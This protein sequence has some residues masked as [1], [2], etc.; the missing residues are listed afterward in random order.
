MR[1]MSDALQLGEGNQEMCVAFIIYQHTQNT[2]ANSCRSAPK[3]SFP[4]WTW[5]LRGLA[6]A[7]RA[8][9]GRKT[10][11]QTEAGGLRVLMGSWMGAA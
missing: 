3:S 7:L 8:Q 9:V 5:C 11:E 10:E 2:S 6:S 1:I 4:T